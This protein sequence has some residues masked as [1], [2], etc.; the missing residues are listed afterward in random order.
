MSAMPGSD[1]I[2]LRSEMTRMG[3]T[4]RAPA[5]NDRQNRFGGFEAR[6][7]HAMPCKKDVAVVRTIGIDTN[8][9]DNGDVFLA[10]HGMCS[11]CFKTPKPILS[12]VRGRSTAGPSHSRH[13]AAERNLVA[14]G[15]S[16]HWSSPI[17]EFAPWH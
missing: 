15:H 6:G 8:C 1:Q 14:T 16:G 9:A 5:P 7:A 2:P 13:F 4:G 3:W 10:R 17:Y 11:S 12:V